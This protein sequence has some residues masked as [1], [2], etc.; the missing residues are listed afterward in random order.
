M[1][2]VRIE[3]ECII[4][5]NVFTLCKKILVKNIIGNSLAKKNPMDTM[6]CHL[7]VFIYTTYISSFRS[8]PVPRTLRPRLKVLKLIIPEVHI[9]YTIVY[10]NEVNPIN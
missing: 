5:F 3:R 4:I 9:F 10:T 1:L 7:L 2:E 6:K 8:I